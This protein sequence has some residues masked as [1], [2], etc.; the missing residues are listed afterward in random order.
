MRSLLIAAFCALVPS[1]AIAQGG[2]QVVDA[3]GCIVGRPC[4]HGRPLP[5]PTSQGTSW[6]VDADGCLVGKPC[7]YRDVRPTPTTL[8]D[9]SGNK[10]VT[11]HNA[12]GTTVETGSNAHT[13]S[14]WTNTQDPAANV[15][16]GIDKSGR[17]WSAPLHTYS[18]GYL[19]NDTPTVD[20]F[21]TADVSRGASAPAPTAGSGS[22]KVNAN[23][24]DGWEDFYRRQRGPDPSGGAVG[25][26]LQNMRPGSLAEAA[27]STAHKRCL[28]STDERVRVAA[29]TKAA[30]LR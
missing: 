23:D 9:R 26:V 4:D 3:Q 5:A 18:S 8:T 24:P 2:S 7:S 14:R 22:S 6:S 15:Q 13:G 29:C 20:D 27:R 12:D 28:T 19:T 25:R 10:Y 11:E 21:P 1:S 17:R 30:E 16:Y